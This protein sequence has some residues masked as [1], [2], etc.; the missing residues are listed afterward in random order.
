ME[1][2]LEEIGHA[3]RRQ[4]PDNLRE[5]LGDLLFVL[6]FAARIGKE[7]G[8]FTIDDVVREIRDKIVRRHPHV[9]GEART[10]TTQEALDQWD[11]IK[12]E[13]KR[14]KRRG[15]RRQPP[16]EPGPRPGPPRG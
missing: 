7:N 3:I 15:P 6:V 16:E 5:E 11:R 14:E 9:F 4:D 10:L 13:E 8:W 2:E 1:G 12:A